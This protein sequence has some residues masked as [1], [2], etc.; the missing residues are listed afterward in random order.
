MDYRKQPSLE[1]SG[2]YLMQGALLPPTEKSS[3]HVGPVAYL[4]MHPHLPSISHP[5]PLTHISSEKK[6]E[7]TFFSFPQCIHRC[8]VDGGEGEGG[9]GLL[10]RLTLG[11]KCKWS[12]PHA[13][14]PP[15]RTAHES[16]DGAT[17]RGR[18]SQQL[19]GIAWIQDKVTRTSVGIKRQSN[20]GSS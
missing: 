13:P 5:S 6:E 12:H 7:S 16:I 1:R 3:I 20:G 14:L 8:I 19:A 9:D 2:G 15:F 4:H 10:R 17:L 18:R 11:N